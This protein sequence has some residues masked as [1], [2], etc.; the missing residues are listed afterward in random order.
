MD[1]NTVVTAPVESAPAT[2]EFKPATVFAFAPEEEAQPV[3]EATEEVSET[4]VEE[5]S[6]QEVDTPAETKSQKDIDAAFGKEKRRIAERERAK[7]EEKMSKDPLR[8]L[9]KLMVDD[10]MQSK[11]LSEEDAVQEATDNFL[12]AIAKREGISPTIAKKLYGTE[13]KK[14]V[15][16]AAEETAEDAHES[17]VERIVREV[18]EA[19]K[20]DGFDEQTAFN[21]PEF[22]QMLTEMP[23]AAAIRVY[24]AE[25]KAANAKQ[26]I[27]EKLMSR[28]RVPQMTKPQQSAS[29]VVDWTKTDS[30][31]FFAEK[32]RRRKMR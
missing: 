25:R 3:D 13:I 8:N 29:P 21:D 17:D 1:E 30:A 16:K 28:Q 9:G 22:I 26:D 2:E 23:A 27:A 12:K 5:E 18:N 4:V 32:E 24:H 10:L 11:G 7:Y 6:S 19:P 14:E 20:P 31:A 15:E